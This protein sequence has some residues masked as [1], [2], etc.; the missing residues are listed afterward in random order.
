MENIPAAIISLAILE[1]LVND[2]FSSALTNRK[3]KYPTGRVM[4]KSK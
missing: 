3:V 4:N 1:Q 2:S